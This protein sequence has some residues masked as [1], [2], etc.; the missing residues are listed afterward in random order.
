MSC[1]R[2]IVSTISF[3]AL[4]S[5]VAACSFDTDPGSSF[6]GQVCFEDADCASGLTCRER[7]CRPVSGVQI[8][9]ASADSQAPDTEPDT[10]V[11]VWDQD[12]VEA[13]C[14]PA[15]SRCGEDGQ[16]EVCTQAGTWSDSAC[17][18]GTTCEA[19]Q[20]EGDTECADQDGDGYLGGPGCPDCNDSDPSINPGAEEVCDNGDDDDCDGAVDEGCQTECCPDG[21]AAEEICSLCECKPFEPEECTVNGQ[22]C[23]NPGQFV[24]GYFCTDEIFGEPRCVGICDNTAPDPDSTCPDEGTVC[25]FGDDGDQGLCLEA[26]DLDEQ[27]GTS[28]FGCFPIGGEDSDND[29]I[30]VP[31]DESKQ[32]GDLCDPDQT[33]QCESGAFCLDFGQGQARCSQACRP[34]EDD[35]T[36]DCD[37]G[38]CF[39]FSPDLGFCQEDADSS[40][41]GDCDSQNQFQTCGVDAQICVPL[42]QFGGAQCL[43]QCRT[44]LGDQDCDNGRG[45]GEIDNFEGV[46]FCVPG[47]GGGGF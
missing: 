40:P 44:E 34:F 22:P 15:T 37:E 45:C 6:A 14:V 10:G 31:T 19:G 16:L 39:A 36:T 26:C 4:A 21:C 30:C 2:L 1:Q 9:D 3:F 33:F 28:G 5:L 13:E 41:D 25:A 42:G 20:C 32:V 7:R 18:Q 43:N 24:N 12:T 29:G 46:G 38:H 8:S 23:S 47:G 11:E 17:P 27:C 35:A